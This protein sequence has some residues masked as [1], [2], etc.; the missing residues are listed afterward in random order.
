M[1]AELTHT[2]DAEGIEDP[3][4]PL[5]PEAID[6]LDDTDVSDDETADESGDDAT[7]EEV[8]PVE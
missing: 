3:V 8:G 7:A 4:A 5:D 2:D 1:E 6:D